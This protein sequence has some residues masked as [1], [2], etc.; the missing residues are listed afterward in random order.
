[1]Y[2]LHNIDNDIAPTCRFC[3]EQREEF[4]H[5]ASDCPPLW[6][7]RHEITSQGKEDA[8]W[9][10]Q[11]ILDFTFIPKINEAFARP[12]HQPISNDSIHEATYHSQNHTYP[13][14]RN[15]PDDIDSE[16]SVMDLSSES[17]SSSSDDDMSTSSQDSDC[18][19]DIDY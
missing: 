18:P 19:I 7:E 8:P 9:S 15:D 1:M 10:P 17:P 3:L 13:E 16:Q 5:L 14:I 4:H 11:Q 2:H 12:L 6:W